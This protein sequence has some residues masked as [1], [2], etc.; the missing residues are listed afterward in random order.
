MASHSVTIQRRLRPL[1]LAFLIQPSDTKSLRSILEINSCLWGG[2]YNAIIPV[3]GRTPTWRDDRRFSPPARDVLRGYVQAFE[4][5]FIVAADARLATGLKVEK[6]RILSLSDVL[7][8]G[9]DEHVQFGLSVF[10]LYRDLYERE[11]Q[12]VRR[13]PAK[14]VHP[15]SPSK[16]MDN[17]IAACFGSFPVGKE[18][19]YFGTGYKDAFDAAG[20]TINESNFFETFTSGV[21]TPLRLG[22]AGLNLRR[23]A[24]SPGPT[25]FYMDATSSIDIIDF[26]NLRAL[27]WKIFP[28]PKQWSSALVAP[29]KSFIE[30]NHLPLQGNPKIFQRT[31]LLKSRRLNKADLD[32]FFREVCPEQ[33]AEPAL[34]MQTLYPRL[35]D[36]WARD[37]DHVQRCEISAEDASL[38]LVPDSGRISFGTLS[39]DFAAETRM[40]GHP[41]WANV[42]RIRDYWP[43]S[44]TAHVI[45]PNTPEVD[46]LLDSPGRSEVS[47]T[48]E[49]IVV[50][51]QYNDWTCRW[52]LPQGTPLLKTWFADKGFNVE[53][54][55]KG[56]IALQMI[57][58][59]G[60]PSGA[61]VVSHPDIVRLLNDM[62]H[63][64]VELPG[65]ESEDGAK[66]QAR[67]LARARFTSK[68]RWIGLLRRIHGNHD[69]QVKR[70]WDALINRGVLRLGLHL[71]CQQ[72][73]QTT[74]Y[75]LDKI[76]P[77][78]ICERCGEKLQFPVGD[79]PRD[80]WSYRTQGPFTV[81]NYAQGSYV[82]A[83][84]LRFFSVALHGEA[85][86]AAGLEDKKNRF[87]VD[88]SLWWDRSSYGGPEPALVFG[89]CKTFGR[90]EQK[91]VTRARTLAK[92][93][94]GVILVFATLRDSLT[95]R[96]K[97]LL[98]GLARS[99]RRFLGAGKTHAPVMVLTAHELT[100]DMGPPY[101][102]KDAGGKFAQF[103]DR[104]R[105]FGGLT[106][107]CDATQQLHLG[108]E[109][110]GEWLQKELERRRQRWERLRTRQTKE[111]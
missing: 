34:M 10:N 98:T 48:T 8:S 35:W 51:C 37:K 60:G 14:V 108:M 82:V 88:F 12:F 53:L 19:E 59:L 92:N 21:G 24:W 39:P 101:C 76:S 33:S 15:S 25:L 65:E 63:G 5:D 91:D 2:R 78:L 86:W 107:M 40:T 3:F 17:F 44:E 72:C 97:R 32:K 9:R 46:R 64:D 103:A 28:V 6:E 43:G 41:K 18:F 57:R 56:R 42:V 67:G 100:H 36:E 94:P 69:V 93:F 1:R 7:D 31:T 73:V 29:C 61:R 99:G 49:G 54:S 95:Q 58:A 84:A 47:A 87:E 68:D 74:W 27:G 106:E 22:S 70:H 4:P 62:A 77:E 81:E 23:L 80:A 52:S 26:W 104:Y 71:K 38:D 102:W 30:E 75:P 79:P 109:S 89:E 50:S 111:A 105:G 55:D 16:E 96:E 45:P 11:F 83:A 66:K 13:H 20:Q 90:F 110:Y 85:T